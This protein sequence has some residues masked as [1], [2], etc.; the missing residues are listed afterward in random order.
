MKFSSHS[1]AS[2]NLAAAKKGFSG[3]T[4]LLSF[5][6]LCWSLRSTKCHHTFMTRVARKT[7]KATLSLFTT[8]L[9]CVCFH[10]IGDFYLL[11]EFMK[12]KRTEIFLSGKNFLLPTPSFWGF[13]KWISN[14]N[15]NTNHLTL[16]PIALITKCASSSRFGCTCRREIYNLKRGALTNEGAFR[17]FGH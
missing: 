12:N 11:H 17:S 8:L 15:P 3:G 2:S 7:Y 14:G 16:T 6:L 1:G 5:R 13:E 10:N 4:E 9:H